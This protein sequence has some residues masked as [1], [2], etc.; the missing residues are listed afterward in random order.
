MI[1][2]EDYD[3]YAAR[4]LG[5]TAQFLNSESLFDL[6]LGSRRA[7]KEEIGRAVGDSKLWRWSSG[8]SKLGKVARKMFCRG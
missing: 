7:V 6:S 1:R 4:G 5:Q 2:Q 3:A 8:E